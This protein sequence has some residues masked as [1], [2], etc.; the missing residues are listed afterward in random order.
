MAKGSGPGATW[1]A[2]AALQDVLLTSNTAETENSHVSDD[3]DVKAQEDSHADANDTSDAS[4]AAGA[5]IADPTVDKVIRILGLLPAT[6]VYLKKEYPTQHQFVI[7]VKRK[8][9]HKQQETNI[10]ADGDRSS[11]L[12]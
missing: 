9:K 8:L 6:K 4:A 7:A 3:A 10:V 2:D 11:I 12:L 5:A 1:T